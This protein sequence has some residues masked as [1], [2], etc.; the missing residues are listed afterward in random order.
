ML[1]A[2]KTVRWLTLG[3]QQISGTLPE[4]YSFGEYLVRTATQSMATN[5]PRKATRKRAKF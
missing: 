3:F 2:G 1:A 4:I 5:C